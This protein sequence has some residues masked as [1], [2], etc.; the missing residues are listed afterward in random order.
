[1]CSL[2]GELYEKKTLLMYKRRVIPRSYCVEVT[3]C[4]SSRG[5]ESYIRVLNVFFI[6]KEYS[7]LEKQKKS[8]ISNFVVS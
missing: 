6:S 1:M 8:L 4:K 3:T 7:I 5:Q 2:N